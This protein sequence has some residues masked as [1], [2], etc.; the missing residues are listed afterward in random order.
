MRAGL[1]KFTAAWIALSACVACIAVVGW[2]TSRTLDRQFRDAAGLDLSVADLLLQT[3]RITALS[4]TTSLLHVASVSPDDMAHQELQI[5]QW[6][7]ELG[8]L[9]H[10]LQDSLQDEQE[11]A[12]LSQFEIL[13]REYAR[14]RDE[15]LLPASRADKAKA[16]VLSGPGGGLDAAAQAALDSLT[17]FS[18]T[19]SAAAQRRRLAQERSLQTRQSALLLGSLASIIVFLAIG[20]VLS[21]RMTRGLGALRQATQHMAIGDLDW[22]VPVRGGAEADG[23]LSA[24]RKS[25]RDMKKVLAAKREADEQLQRQGTALRE[26]RAMLASAE[27]RFEATLALVDRAIITCDGAG[28]VLALNKS[29]ERLTG[30]TQEAAHGRPLSEVCLVSGALTRGQGEGLLQRAVQSAGMLGLEDGAILA[31]R[32]GQEHD[33]SLASAPLYDAE[34]HLLGAVFVLRERVKPDE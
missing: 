23:I 8:A 3:S 30:W 25:T 1:S 22:D 4:Q 28:H 29:A 7:S 31:S 33:V 5:S 26:A 14:I 20:L 34:G 21:S 15:E 9:S 18:D 17:A 11:L 13:W 10:R 24:L 16:A 27:Q 6:E 12:R 32:D 2:Y 19:H